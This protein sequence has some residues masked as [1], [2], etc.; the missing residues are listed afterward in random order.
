MQAMCADIRRASSFL[1]ATANFIHHFVSLYLCPGLLCPSRF[2]Q[3]YNKQ[4]NFERKFLK[5]L[6][7]QATEGANQRVY[8]Y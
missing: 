8:A 2:G 4:V 7:L 5:K 3:L 6:Y 1:N